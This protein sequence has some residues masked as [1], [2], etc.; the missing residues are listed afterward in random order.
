M[1]EVGDTSLEELSAHFGVSK[2]T[3]QSHFAKH[4]IKKG[5]RSRELAAAVEAEVFSCEL[6]DKEFLVECAKAIKEKTY[7][8][9]KAVENLVM[10]QLNLAQKDPSQAYKSAAAL[11]S[12]S[13]AA[14]A[15]ERLHHLKKSALGLDKDPTVAEEMPLLKVRDLSKEDLETIKAD[16]EKHRAEYEVIDDTEDE[17][18]SHVD[19]D[20]GEEKDDVIEIGHQEPEKHD[21][22]EEAEDPAPTAEGC[23]LVRGAR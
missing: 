22:P 23:R 5:T 14:A 9:A 20:P 10:A 1:W 2:R 4:D 7:A 21:E 13:V 16:H 6:T 11:K 8:N 3:L 17:P 12:L 15:L 18:A 19:D